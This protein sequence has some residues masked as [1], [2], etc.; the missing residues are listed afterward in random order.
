V[1]PSFKGATEYTEFTEGTEGNM[2]FI[3]E[4]LVNSVA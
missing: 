3:Y 2:L 1:A 4:F